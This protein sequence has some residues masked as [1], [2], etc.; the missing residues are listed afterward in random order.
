MC[1]IFGLSLKPGADMRSAMI[2]FKILGLYN[3]ERGRDS[4]GVFVNN[5]I[6]KNTKEFD[7][8][9]EDIVLPTNSENK[10]VI[11]H[12]RQGSAGYKKTVEEAH[13]FLI[14]DDLVFTHNGTIRN[15]K[16]LCEKYSVDEKDYLVDSHLLGSLYFTEGHDVLSHYRGAAALAFTYLS[17]PNTLYLYHGSS[18][19]YKTGPMVEERPLFFMET[20]DGIFYSS[21][22]SSLEA[23]RESEED[24]VF[25]LEYNTIFKI[26]DGEFDFSETIK[27]ERDEANIFVYTPPAVVYGN[28]YGGQYG[29]DYYTKNR[30]NYSRPGLPGVDIGYTDNMSI[31]IRLIT[32]ESLPIKV[33]DSIKNGL[34]INGEN[35][36]YY[37][38]GRFYET[39]HTLVTGPVYVRKG[40]IISDYENKNSELLFFYRGV[41]L[42]DKEAF[43]LIREMERSLSIVPNWANEPTKFNFALE[44]SKYSQYP[45]TNLLEEYNPDLTTNNRNFWYSNKVESKC[46]SFTPK[47]GGRSYNIK[48][49]VLVTI[50]SSHREKTLLTSSHDVDMQI[51]SLTSIQ[52][53]TQGGSS[54]VIP[55]LFREDG[56]KEE[57]KDDILFFHEISF[58]TRE[59]FDKVWGEKE[60][61]AF[62]KFVAYVYVR[63]FSMTALEAEITEYCMD[64]IDRSIKSNMSIGEY[65]DMDVQGDSDLLLEYY[66]KEFDNKSDKSNIIIVSDLPVRSKLTPMDFCDESDENE[67]K[68]EELDNTVESCLISLEDIKTSCTNLNKETQSD[69]A[70]STSEILTNGVDNILSNL[71]DPLLRFKKE[72]LFRKVTKIRE[73][74]IIYDGIL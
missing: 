21:L 37:H 4:T 57:K 54:K 65:L 8:F 46:D 43:S 56:G 30:S 59:E 39:P 42:K 14:N 5:N 74:K 44:I 67:Q 45:V 1:G 24:E 17:S 53:G 34:K 11:G 61:R 70:I 36:I 60:H 32:K 49:G 20:E 71:S 66:E 27:I 19:D 48:N 16:D 31:D 73:S 52:T 72:N 3:I 12:N 63:D 51:L 35:F 10:I 9:I 22:K 18:K 58:Q 64:I 23:I 50:R 13:P 69:Y 7:N 26:T 38:F 2:K 62:R 33:L 41:M 40:G 28:H 55:T 6:I 25:T 29:N 47:Y 68:E 15:V